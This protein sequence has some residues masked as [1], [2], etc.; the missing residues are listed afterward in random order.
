MVISF[1]IG[2]AGCIRECAIANIL[3]SIV[4]WASGEKGGA[5]TSFL[6]RPVEAA[7]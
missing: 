6:R 3:S 2:G 7:D 1:L 4:L 5:Y